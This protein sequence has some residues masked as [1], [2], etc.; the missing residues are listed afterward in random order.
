MRLR[1]RRT[2]TAVPDAQPADEPGLGDDAVAL[3]GEL[4]LL[5]RVPLPLRSHRRRQAAVGYAIEETI[6]EPLEAV[7]VVLGPELAPGEHLAV[8]VSRRVMDA[9]LP[10]VGGRQRLV[11]DVLALPV[12]AEGSSAVR[13]TGG[14]VL[15]RRA[16]GTGYAASAAAFPAF[17]RADGSPPIVLFGGRLPDGVPVA[18]TGLLPPRPDRELARFD[19]LRGAYAR[20]AGG[21][22]VARRVV[23]VLAAALVA[24]AGLLAADGYALRRL[25]AAHE[26]AVRSELAARL[27][28]LPPS[29]PLDAAL[30][31][32][33][34]DSAAPP[35]GG[36]LP[37]MTRVA[38]ALS[39][40]SGEVS[41]K[42]LAYDAAGS[43]LTVSIEAADLAALQ[44]AE[45]TLRLQGLA[46]TPGAAT[47][48]EGRAE[49]QLV[50][51]GLG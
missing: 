21:R 5:L 1:T 29:L 9:W 34:P 26:A 8:V 50:I 2:Q 32:V 19:L 39:P 37:L 25:A 12:P 23:A 22:R 51:G 4:A 35:G 44:R 3:P 41:L 20:A 11:P 13:E 18:A 28:D 36:F 6:A 46:V 33:T 7:H 40:A 27:P 14:R 48:A 24:H 17:W 30:K 31:R 43:A 38:E 42:R 47:T 16:D 10:R 45:E 15:A 49:V